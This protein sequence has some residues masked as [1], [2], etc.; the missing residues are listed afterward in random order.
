MI[1]TPVLA[2]NKPAVHCVLMGTQVW[3]CT[4]ERHR[5]SPCLEE[6]TNRSKV[7][8]L[9]ELFRKT[10]RVV[11]AISEPGYEQDDADM[12]DRP[13]IHDI[14]KDGVQEEFSRAQPSSG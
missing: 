5:R 12:P 6:L 11:D 14:A 7:P 13:G 3:R 8:P 9:T 2:E 1:E 4:P 10:T